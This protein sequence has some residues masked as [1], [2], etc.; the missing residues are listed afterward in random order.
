MKCL[1][2]GMEEMKA[3]KNTY[4]AFYP[5]LLTFWGNRGKMKSS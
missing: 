3:S 4:F 5:L 2:C 1:S